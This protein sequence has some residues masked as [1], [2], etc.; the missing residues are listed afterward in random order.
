MHCKL[1]GGKRPSSFMLIAGAVL[2]AAGLLRGAPAFGVVGQNIGLITDR[3]FD[4]EAIA[5]EQG[6]RLTVTGAFVCPEAVRNSQ[7]QIEA[8]VLQQSTLAVFRGVTFGECRNSS[9]TFSIEGPVQEGSLPF[10][11]GPA[12]AC[13]LA[14]TGRGAPI[15]SVSHWCAFVTIT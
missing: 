14:A 10:E 12:L 9:G 5:S 7:F 13:G 4:P 6:Q 15:N 3:N 11:P 8:S 1:R 2:L